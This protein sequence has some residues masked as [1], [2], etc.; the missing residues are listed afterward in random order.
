[1]ICFYFYLLIHIICLRDFPGGASGKEPA[2]S[3]RRLRDTGLIPGLG[4]SPGE[5]HGN[6]L[7]YP[8]SILAWRIPWTEEPDGLQSMGAQRVKHNWATNT[9]NSFTGASAIRGLF[10]GRG[11]ERISR[12]VFLFQE[13]LFTSTYTKILTWVHLP[14]FFFFFFF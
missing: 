7:Q 11:L 1:M 5:G 14:G 12:D 6:P 4:K 2:Y 3:C 10:L 8:S 9:L 13:L